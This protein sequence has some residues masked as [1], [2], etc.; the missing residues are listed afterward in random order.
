MEE[1]R[2]LPDFFEEENLTSSR[3]ES[4]KG[5]LKTFWT[6]LGSRRVDVIF[7]QVQNVLL[8]LKEKIKNGTATNQE[9]WQ[10]WALVNEA[11]LSDLL[12]LTNVSD[13]FDGDG[14]QE[15]KPKL[16][17]LLADDNT[18]NA[19]EGSDSNKKEEMERT[20]SGTKKASSEIQHLPL[21]LQ[22]QN[23]KCSSACLAKKA[24][25]SYKGENP[26]KM[27]ILFHFQRRHAKADCLSKSLDVNYKAPCGRSL[28]SFR[29]VQNYL[30]ETKCNFLFVDHFSFNTYVLLG[31]NT[32]NP[33]PL[34]FD[35]DISNGAESVPISFCNNLDR[36]RL[37]YFKYRKSSW[38]RGYYLNNFSSLFVDSC[39]CT[40]GCIDRSKCACL[41]LTARGCSKTSL[42]S[43]SK[44]CR[45]YRYKRLE[46]PVPS[47]IYECSVLCRCD[48]LMCQNR[49]VQHGIQVRL[50]VFNTEK[51]GWGVRCLDDIDKG[52]FVCTY[53]GRLMS[54]A[55]VL[56]DAGQELKERSAVNDR[57]HG[58]FS[59]KRKLDTD[60][61]NSVIELVQTGKHD[62]LENKESLSQTV[63][64]EN[65]ST[66]VHPENSSIA[67][68][69]P[70]RT[71]FF[72]S[73]QLKMVHS[74]SSDED[75]SSQIHQSSKT[76]VNSGTKKGKEK[77]TEEQKEDHPMEVGQTESVGVDSE[78][79]KRKS[80]SLQGVDCGKSGVLDDT[81]VARPSSNIPL[82]ADCKEE[83][84]RQ[85]SQDAFCEEA[86]GDGMLPKNASEENIYV[87]DATKEGNVGRF[88]NHSCCPNLFAQSVF[89][90]THNRSF[91][92]VA[93]FTNRHVKAGTELTWDYGYEAGSMPETEI[94]CQC[95]VQKCRKNER[96][97]DGSMGV[98]PFPW[99]KPSGS[100]CPAAPRERRGRLSTPCSRSRTAARTK[101][102]GGARASPPHHVTDGAAAR[103]FPSGPAPGAG[104]N[105]CR[106]E[107][108]APGKHRRRATR[109]CSGPGW[110][111]H[112]RAGSVGAREGRSERS[113]REPG[114]GGAAFFPAL[115]AFWIMAKMVRRTCAFCSEGAAGSVM[116]VAKESDIAAHQDCLLFSSGFVESE[117]YNPENL[118]IRFD[119]ASV[120]KEL[121]RGKRLVCNFCR[122]KGATVGC[123]ERACRRSYHYYCA[124]CDD[125]AIET[126]QVK[127]VYRVFCPKHDPSNR[128]SHY[129]A[130]NKKRRYTLTSPTITEEMK[131]EEKAEENHF[132]TLKRKNN[133][134]KVQIDLVRKC[135]Q[136]GLLDDIFEEMLDTLHLA[137]EKLMDDNTSE[138]EYEE[139]VM[140]LFDCGLFEN[141]LTNIHSGKWKQQREAEMQSGRALQIRNRRKN[142]RTS[143]KQKKTGSQD[144][145]TAGLKRNPSYPREH[146][147]YI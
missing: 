55:E 102:R 71:G 106:E 9:C 27:P 14:V 82:K 110:A 117:E 21:N 130:A 63:D 77:S 87:L 34:V 1:K 113:V 96:G 11:N 88:L 138:T 140:A 74:A 22:Y 103:A 39:D 31:R 40:D 127:G 85:S 41:Q 128:T 70:G 104:A 115:G 64:S 76:K 46:G 83:N 29:D 145:A 93:F 80:L 33:E 24:A 49:V 44:R 26:L 36:A 75:N 17:H 45:G 18:A 118:D 129:G 23:H 15:T 143:R 132:Q 100:G 109:A 35:F 81:C 59:K 58:V 116:Y 25:G 97:A 52:T 124:L 114:A 112:F 43:G 3:D 42:S 136:A 12:T 66:L 120:L 139:T 111:H 61:S 137:Q 57:N 144:R 5:D 37:P 19:V 105:Q 72:H 121:R 135:K 142:T 89:V 146:S 48:K 147:Q 108:G 16:Q 99:G 56:G 7:E 131:T 32:M 101:G 123:E 4:I 62:I 122:K 68:T 126:D 60:C 95:G 91:P 47:G 86:D 20:W 94:S 84:S 51:K 90:E 78:R 38:P 134:H 65:K 6:Q 13:G 67:T 2:M 79:C 107:G 30:F 141:I 73:H 119:V 133:R 50:Q 98:S 92:W 28:R 8:L 69:R 54:R 53:S 125:A 10:A